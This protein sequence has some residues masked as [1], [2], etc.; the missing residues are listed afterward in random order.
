MFVTMAS[1]RIPELSTY[2]GQHLHALDNDQC[3]MIHLF[4]LT[5][6]IT[7][8]VIIHIEKQC[9]QTIRRIVVQ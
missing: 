2:F 9:A 1:I 7:L 4:F 6:G 3:Y 5:T 8:R